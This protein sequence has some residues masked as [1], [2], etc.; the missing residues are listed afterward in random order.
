MRMFKANSILTIKLSVGYIRVS[1]KKQSGNLVR[2]AQMVEDYLI[3]K[4]N[5]FKITKSAGF[6]INYKTYNYMSYFVWL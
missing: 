1:S 4:G 5:P 3:A 2:Q 6:G